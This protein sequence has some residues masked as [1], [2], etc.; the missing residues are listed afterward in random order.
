MAWESRTLRSH[1]KRWLWITLNRGGVVLS[2]PRRHTFI[3]I[4]VNNYCGYNLRRIVNF[5]Q[6]EPKLVFKVLSHYRSGY[7]GSIQD[8]LFKKNNKHNLDI[9]IHDYKFAKIY[10]SCAT[11]LLHHI[12]TSS[13]ITEQTESNMKSFC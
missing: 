2:W 11:F 8:Q 5:F 13:V 12:L 1:Y 9:W 6:G 4:Y 10:G 7:W 3:K